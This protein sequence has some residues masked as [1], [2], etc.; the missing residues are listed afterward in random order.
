MKGT[1]VASDK[2]LLLEV[3]HCMPVVPN[4]DQRA[5]C[6]VF[7]FVIQPAQ[8]GDMT[9]LCVCVW[10]DVGYIFNVAT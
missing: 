5:I 3:L 10:T 4:Y 7:N 9:L 6:D 8:H 1:N 2:L